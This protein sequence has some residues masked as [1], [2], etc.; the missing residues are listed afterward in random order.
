MEFAGDGPLILGG[1]LNLRPSQH[2]R[3]LRELERRY[4]LAAPTGPKAIDHLLVR[5]LTWSRSRGAAG[6]RGRGRCA[7]PTT[8]PSRPRSA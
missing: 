2:A 1:D 3:R 5:G 4:G 6:A 8:L 7:S